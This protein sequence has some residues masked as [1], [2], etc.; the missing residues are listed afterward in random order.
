MT[1]TWSWTNY[2]PHHPSRVPTG[3]IVERQINSGDFTILTYSVPP[4]GRSYTD[5]LTEDQALEV[6]GVGVQL[7]Y[8]V[9][10]YWIG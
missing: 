8:R 1:I 2:D 5:T 4:A 6:F 7:A 10:A 3:F 9:R